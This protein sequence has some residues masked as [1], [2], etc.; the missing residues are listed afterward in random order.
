MTYLKL[1]ILFALL[2]FTTIQ[3]NNI[4]VRN[5]Y[6]G[7]P[8]NT[9]IKAQELLNSLLQYSNVSTT[10]LYFGKKS[11]MNAMTGE[12]SD[13]YVFKITDSSNTENPQRLLIMKITTFQ[14]N[15]FVD[16]YAMIPAPVTGNAPSIAYVN[17]FI[18]AAGF[19]FSFVTVGFPTNA[20]FFAANANALPCNLIKEYFTYFYQLFGSKFK[21]TLN[22]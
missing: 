8:Q 21:K 9:I 3:Q 22:N 12:S 7:G 16:N 10:V 6:I 18:A 20:D 14:N 5:K 13:Y 15:T 1:T 11:A 17:A 4:C 2:T 19:N